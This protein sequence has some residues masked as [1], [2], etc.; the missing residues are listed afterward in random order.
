MSATAIL[1]LVLS[2][3]S[4][5]VT[6]ANFFRSP[7]KE[8]R[9]KVEDALRRLTVLETKIDVFWKSVS[10][11]S[12]QAL[13]SPH[14]PQFDRLIELF[15]QERL[16]DQQLVEFKRMLR[17]VVDDPNETSFRKKSAL[18]VLALIHIRFEVAGA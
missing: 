7:V 1:S 16:D 9:D 6:L 13:H 4:V 15:Q 2:G 12:A 11:S 17:E 18:E 8:Q 3:I 10:F 14:T 5:M